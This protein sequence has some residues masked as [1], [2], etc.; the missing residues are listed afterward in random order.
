MDPISA[1]GLIS[2]ALQV[3]QVIT[4]T[5]AGLAHLREKYQHADLT[6]RTL[7]QQLTT[8]RAAI[9]QL[10]DWTRVR[11]R[12]SPAEYNMSLDV[13]LDG[14]R[15][16][17][18]AFSDEVA[19]LTQDTSSNETGIGFRTRMRVVWKEDVMRGHQE[20]LHSQ[21]I[22]LQL[23]VQACQCRSSA[24]QVELLRKAESRHIIW[25]VADDAATLRSSTRYSASRADTASNLSQRESTIGSTVFDF[26]RTLGASL[27]Y[28][29]IP[30]RS[31]SRPETWSTTSNGDH[32]Q[33]TDEGYV[34]GVA[35]STSVS[36][37]GSLVLPGHPSG[38]ISPTFGHSNSVGL[39]PTARTPT[40]NHARR[41]KSDSTHAPQ[42][43]RSSGSKRGKIQSV[44]RRL[45]VNSMKSV[46]S[47]Q[48]PTRGLTD[49]STTT[50]RRQYNRDVNTSIDLTSSDGAS[51]P[52][53]VKTAQTGSWPDIE[54]LIERG[55]DL[56]A[57][58]FQSRRT[59]LLVAAHCGNE[60]VVDLL[61][62]K[63][64]RL[65]AVDRSGSTA[66][67]LA[68]S[69]GH[70]GVLELLL[71]ETLNIEARDSRG[72]TALWVA[73]ERAK[74]NARADAQMTALHVAS[75]QGADL[76]AKDGTMMTALHYACENVNVD[77][78]GCDRRTPLICA[79]ARKA[80]TGSSDDAGMTALHWAAY[81]GHT[82]AVE[83]LS[84]RK[85]SLAKVNSAKRTALHLAAMNSQFAVVEL[86]LR[87]EMPVETRCQSGLTALHYACLANSTEISKL[88]LMSGAD[89]EAQLEGELQRHPVHIAAAQGSMGLLNLL[90]DKGASLEVRDALGYRALGVACR[91]GHT[92]AVQNLL[93][94]KSPVHMASGSW[95][96]DDSPL[97]LAAMKRGAF[98]LKQD[99]QDWYP[100]QYAAYHGHS[101]VLEL[102]LALLQFEG[103]GFAPAADISEERKR[104]QPETLIRNNAS[105]QGT[106]LVSPGSLPAHFVSSL[107][108]LPSTLEQGLPTSEQ[109]NLNRPS[110]GTALEQNLRL[111]S[112]NSQ[113]STTSRPPLSHPTPVREGPIQPGSRFIDTPVSIIEASTART[114]EGPPSRT[115][116]RESWESNPLAVQRP[117][118]VLDSDSESIASYSTA[119][120][121]GR[122]YPTRNLVELPA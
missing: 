83:I 11:L 89:I 1:F 95:A 70:C 118:L 21:V 120:E 96:R 44:L 110:L 32:S 71:S 85:S 28:Q 81:N 94:R 119:S 22:A 18:E 43:D 90:C 80:S 66:L 115:E 103:I 17:M 30:E 23:L 8:I 42:L 19:V 27:P 116:A 93:D 61:I 86:L 52:L 49:G 113:I 36:R 74:A 56:E 109:R 112:R 67:H 105:S 104:E 64:A 117:A 97:C 46:S 20:R 54:K 25:K 29:R 114:H 79:A 68:A 101:R 87:K 78:P 72:R 75:K 31:Y 91:T 106:G 45:S 73:A 84:S 16:V 77:V 35:T 69:R 58:H 82:E 38:T 107:A 55:C 50:R 88:L 13:A 7:E 14:C 33:T 47:P 9:T 59:A 122:E 100:Y 60:A 2:G 3:G 4:D 99:E 102:L 15:T 65:D 98:V 53:I 6:I 37:T 34:S 5:L 51:A 121:G 63:H 62:Q 24:E 48:V 111:E 108:T 57:K 10:D 12:D 76:E 40:L 26:D 41:S 39:S 92:A